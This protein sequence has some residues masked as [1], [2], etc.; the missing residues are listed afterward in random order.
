MV[1]K[2]L[3]LGEAM[4][5]LNQQH[6][7]NYIEGFGGDTSNCAVAAARAGADV[8]VIGAL[9]NDHF[10]KKILKLWQDENIE[11][12]NIY[13][14]DIHKT[15]LYFVNHDETGHHF[16]YYR[17]NSAASHFRLDQGSIEAIKNASILHISGIS[18]AISQTACDSVYQ[19]IDIAKD[20]NVKISFDTNLRLKLW[21]VKRAQAIINHVAGMADYLLPGLDDAQLLTGFDDKDAICDYYHHLGAKNIALTLGDQGVY[22][23]QESG[24]EYIPARKVKAVDATG[25]GDTFDGNF[26]TRILMGDDIIAAA[27]YANIAASLSVQKYGAISSMP[28]AK[29]VMEVKD[30]L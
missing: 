18:L 23:T 8:E 15:G 28:N 27:Q 7:E 25:A 4:I 22:V 29:D 3:C 24:R 30:T 1:K 16:S 13:L 21:P 2:L 19:A 6:N 20:N 26:L 5:E 9:G 17:E 11:H 10:G 12:R 14:D